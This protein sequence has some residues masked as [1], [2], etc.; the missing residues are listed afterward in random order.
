L[1]H[2]ALVGYTFPE[3]LLPRTMEVM[4]DSDLL[5]ERN[6]HRYDITLKL[7]EQAGIYYHVLK[8]EGDNAL[9]QM[10]SLVFFGDY[11]SYYLA[12]LNQEDPTAIH[13]ID[14]LKNSLANR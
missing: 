10:M 4:L 2:T 7:L 13:S 6:R 9:S 5:H 8:G 11:V 12:M 14:F 3:D 1:N